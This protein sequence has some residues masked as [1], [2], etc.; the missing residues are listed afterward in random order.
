[1]QSYS[2]LSPLTSLDE[3]LYIMSPCKWNWTC[4][5][6]KNRNPMLQVTFKTERNSESIGLRE[7]LCSKPKISLSACISTEFV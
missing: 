7:N 6:I 3:Q 2:V 5:F 1:M 4:L